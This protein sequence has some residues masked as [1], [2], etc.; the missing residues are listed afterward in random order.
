MTESPI[1]GLA[2]IVSGAFLGLVAVV[3]IGY[4]LMA[5]FNMIVETINGDNHE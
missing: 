4:I 1:T 5:L 2:I 3:Y